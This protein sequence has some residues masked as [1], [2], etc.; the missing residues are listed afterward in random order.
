[1]SFILIVPAYLSAN[2]LVFNI[3][4]DLVRKGEIKASTNFFAVNNHDH[5][6]VKSFIPNIRYGITDSVELNFAMIG[7]ELV[8]VSYPG[9]SELYEEGGLY[10]G[11]SYDDPEPYFVT[12]Q[13]ECKHG[14]TDFI[15]ALKWKADSNYDNNSGAMLSYFAGCAFP[16]SINFDPVV[17]YTD[18][19]N[20]RF[21]TFPLGYDS[22]QT[23]L[24]SRA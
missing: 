21:V 24:I 6:S 20:E 4:P 5:F 3:N 2:K 13:T 10:E 16:G 23:S 19:N 18:K 15:V 14:I 7:S 17:A 1:M 22:G 11:Y 8:K 9:L 12:E